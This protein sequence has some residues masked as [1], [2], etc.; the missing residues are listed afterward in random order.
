MYDWHAKNPDKGARFAKAM[1]SVSQGLDPGSVMITDWLGARIRGQEEADSAGNSLL[2]VEVAGKN[3]GLDATQ[4]ASQF[5]SVSYQ[6]QDISSVLS[7]I[8]VPTSNARVM[9]QAPWREEAL[10]HKPGCRSLVFLLRSVLWNLSDAQ[11]VEV[12]RSFI[13]A[14]QGEL[15]TTARKISVDLLVCDLVSPAFGSFE[16]H[17]ERAFRR[18]DVTLMTMH[19]VKQRT[20]AEWGALFF[21]ASPYFQVSRDPKSMVL[22]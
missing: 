16:P 5:P 22:P 7:A 21:E 15:D 13:P 8:S 2:L 17:V 6:R 10:A 18:R 14:I 9:P 11:V 19:N 3:G 20:A 4:V 12:L 1:A